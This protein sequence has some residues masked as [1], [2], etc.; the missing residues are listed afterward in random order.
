MTPALGLT[1]YQP[2]NACEVLPDGNVLTSFRLLNTVAIID[3][4]S[5]AFV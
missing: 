2:D 3:R 1:V 4:H 5:G